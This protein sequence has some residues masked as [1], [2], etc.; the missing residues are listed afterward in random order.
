MPAS[1][2]VSGSEVTSP[3]ATHRAS[4]ASSPAASVPPVTVAA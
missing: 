3:G 2:V 4:A 1:P